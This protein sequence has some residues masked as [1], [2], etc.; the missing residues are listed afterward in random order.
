MAIKKPLT[1]MDRDAIIEFLRPILDH[2][3]QSNSMNTRHTYERLKAV[4]AQVEALRDVDQAQAASLKGLHNGLK[5][6]HD[7]LDNH[8]HRAR[9]LEAMHNALANQVAD[10]LQTTLDTLG[11]RVAELDA[12]R[13][14]SGTEGAR[15]GEG[16]HNQED[17]GLSREINFLYERPQ[18]VMRCEDQGEL[19]SAARALLL[20]APTPTQYD[21]APYGCNPMEYHRAWMQAHDLLA[22]IDMEKRRGT[23]KKGRT[24]A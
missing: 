15:C 19:L 24:D 13:T 1:P 7:R 21:Q 9:Q 10:T 17:S 3:M 22:N 16:L 20:W 18:G 8:E 6:A 23:P 11:K 14:G 4:E 12:Q 5:S 2:A